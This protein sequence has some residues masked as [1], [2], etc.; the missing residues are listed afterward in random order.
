MREPSI[1]D[2]IED[3]ADKNFMEKL[4]E[5]PSDEADP[6]AQMLY[7]LQ[8]EQVA[9][10][11]YEIEG[12]PPTKKEVVIY[13]LIRLYPLSTGIIK[14][15]LVND[16]T[17]PINFLNVYDSERQLLDY[18]NET[19]TKIKESSTAR[20]MEVTNY[21]KETKNLI[22]DMAVLS[23]KI[24]EMTE[25]KTE[26]NEKLEEKEALEKKLEELEADPYG[27]KL[28][29]EIALITEQIDEKEKSLE[30]K[31]RELGKAKDELKKIENALKPYDTGKAESKF[32]D[33]F[34]ALQRTIKVLPKEG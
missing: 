22:D 3:L 23:K 20:S 2:F 19:I 31:Q 13:S 8:D 17:K 33:A 26:Y 18:M 30:T 9:A 24:K 28:A 27:A 7:F 10:L 12:L 32:K 1:K 14:K 25:G 34:R 6:I 5:R 29:E 16:V 15:L 4:L 11:M 21:K